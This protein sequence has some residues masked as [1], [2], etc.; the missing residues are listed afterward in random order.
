MVLYKF[1]YTSFPAAQ[2]VYRKVAWGC[3]VILF[4]GFE[5][6]YYNQKYVECVTL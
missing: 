1:E 3:L 2:L 5:F 6:A 4:F